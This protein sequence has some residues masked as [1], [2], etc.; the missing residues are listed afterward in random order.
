MTDKEVMEYFVLI[1]ELNRKKSE[2]QDK[3]ARQRK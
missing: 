1:T 2:E 3:A